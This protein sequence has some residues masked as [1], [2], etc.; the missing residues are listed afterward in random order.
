[1]SLANTESTPVRYGYRRKYTHRRPPPPFPGQMG[2]SLVGGVSGPSIWET[3][4]T[5][6]GV[7]VGVERRE[8]PS[9]IAYTWGKPFGHFGGLGH[10]S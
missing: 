3:G 6:D 1:M 2:P 7:P 5:D 9:V 8:A 10:T 4:G